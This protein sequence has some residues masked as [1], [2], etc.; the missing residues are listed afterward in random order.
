MQ[1][2]LATYHR[3][4]ST[5]SSQIKI[6]QSSAIRPLLAIIPNKENQME[7][8]RYFSLALVSLSTTS[9]IH[10]AI[11]ELGALEALFSFAKAVD[12]MSQY[13]VA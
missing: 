5:I 10:A 1:Q 12:P 9:E 7:T 2:L 3:S 11:L 13:Y 6:T 8:K 4:L